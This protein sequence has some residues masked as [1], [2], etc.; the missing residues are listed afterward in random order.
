MGGVVVNRPRLTYT[1][2]SGAS[3]ALTGS[4]SETVMATITIPAGVLG[5]NG[6]VRVRTLWSATNNANNKTRRIRYGALGAGTGG[7]VMLGIASASV[8]TMQHYTQWT[9]RNATNSQVGMA[10]GAGT[11]GFTESTSAIATAAIDTTAATDV[12]ITGQLATGTDTL[13]LESYSVEVI[14][15]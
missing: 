12:V 5:P 10:T 7:A 9:N 6:S 11:G 13:T 2:I 14:V 15:P 4:T 8:A 1:A 3:V